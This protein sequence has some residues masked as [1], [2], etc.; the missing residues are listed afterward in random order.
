[1]IFLIDENFP[2]G[3][4]TPFTT[5]F[6][7][8]QFL[9]VGRAQGFD[10]GM[11]DVALFAE[12]EK[13]RVDAIITGDVKQL[14]GLDRINERNACRNAGLHWIGVPAQAH[15][16]GRLRMHGQVGQLVMSLEYVA[17]LMDEADNPQ[18]FLLRKGPSKA[19]LESGYPQDL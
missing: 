12:A 13:R 11:S 16:K 15:A 18:A 3:A 19:P 7:K 8:H 9:S 1:M 2:G 4:F 5:L 17:R 6:R 14:L 10:R